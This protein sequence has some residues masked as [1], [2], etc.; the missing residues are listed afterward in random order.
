MVVNEKELEVIDQIGKIK[1]DILGVVEVKL[2]REIRSNQIFPKG[3]MIGRKKKEDKGGEL[4]LI[5]KVKFQEIL[6]NNPFNQYIM[7]KVTQRKTC[8]IVLI[9][10][11]L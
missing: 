1:S 2:T 10:A 4:A 6:E 8:K 9:I 3:Y 7:G 5:V 11:I